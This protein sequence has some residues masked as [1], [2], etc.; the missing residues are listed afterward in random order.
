[1]DPKPTPDPTPAFKLPL[2]VNIPDLVESNSNK[3]PFKHTNSGAVSLTNGIYLPRLVN[4]LGDEVNC[5]SSSDTACPSF[6]RVWI[7][8]NNKI[9]QDAWVYLPVDKKWSSL[10]INPRQRIFGFM[11]YGD[12]YSDG[13]VLS[14]KRFDSENSIW[15]STPDGFTAK[16]LNNTTYKF[17]VS[18]KSLSNTMIDPKRPNA[19]TYSSSVKSFRIDSGI[20]EGEYYYFDD[21]KVYSSQAAST[22]NDDSSY[23][24]IEAYRAAHSTTEKVVCAFKA[25]SGFGRTG[26]VFNNTQLGA[27]LYSLDSNCAKDI[28]TTGPSKAVTEYLTVI[29]GKRILLFPALSFDSVTDKS[30]NTA[31]TLNDNGVPAHGRRYGV[32]YA[33]ETQS[34]YINQKGFDEWLKTVANKTSA[35]VYPSTSN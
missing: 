32:G 4:L 14:T 29:N 22:S 20:S 28:D 13:S 5:P 21:A 31:I 35:L 16:Y 23:Q 24:N 25:E 10:S 19:G 8:S 34:G 12:L 9:H 7:D 17:S 6:I 26:L 27:T 33:N 11:G 3:L 15:T 2:S 30:Y 18:D 1:P